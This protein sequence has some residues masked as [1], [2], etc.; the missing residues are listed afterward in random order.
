MRNRAKRRPVGYCVRKAVLETNC[1]LN[2]AGTLYFRASAFKVD[3]DKTER[4]HSRINVLRA[5][6][7]RQLELTVSNGNGPQPDLL[8][9]GESP[10]PL[11][12]IL[13]LT[14]REIEHSRTYR[15]VTE[16]VRKCNYGTR[17][18]DHVAREEIAVDCQDGTQ[19]LWFESDSFRSLSTST[20]S[21]YVAMTDTA[22]FVIQRF[23]AIRKCFALG[24]YRRADLNTSVPLGSFVGFVGILK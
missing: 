1:L 24:D 12:P 13:P 8:D 9:T 15:P 7:H 16:F 20:K 10:A 21:D 14:C 11:K 23:I 5:F 17:G 3:Y 4:K 19:A 18:D 2:S 22:N 6:R